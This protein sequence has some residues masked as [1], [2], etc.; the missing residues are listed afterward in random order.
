[1]KFCID[2]RYFLPRFAAD[3]V[4]DA[5]LS[6]CSYL[7]RRDIVTGQQDHWYCNIQRG[8]SLSTACGPEG[9]FHLPIE[10]GV[11]ADE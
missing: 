2:C 8:S 7:D 5:S 10:I 11:T 9:R 6:K 3:K 4:P 1:M